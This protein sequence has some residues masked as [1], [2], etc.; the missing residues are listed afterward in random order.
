MHVY[1]VTHGWLELDVGGDVREELEDGLIAV[2]DG[3]S[4][5]LGRLENGEPEIGDSLL[6]LQKS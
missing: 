2:L 3:L 5:V 6:A 1:K 4:E